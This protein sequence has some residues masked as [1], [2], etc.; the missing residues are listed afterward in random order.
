LKVAEAM[1][2]NIVTVDEG[3]S[4]TEASISTRNKGEGCAIILRQGKP[5]GIVTERDVT[6]KVAGEGLDP[7]NVKTS[8]TL[9]LR[10]RQKRQLLYISKAD[11]FQPKKEGEIQ[12]AKSALLTSNT[13]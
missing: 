4:T 12:D 13:H 3:I 7:K 10:L 1:R 8:T 9:S 5:F 2:K 11:I 6:W